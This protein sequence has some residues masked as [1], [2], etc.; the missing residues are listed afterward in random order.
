MLRLRGNFYRK[1]A[2]L[3][4]G[5]SKVSYAIFFGTLFEKNPSL[6]KISVRVIVFSFEAL[7]VD[8]SDAQRKGLVTA[9]TL[10]AKKAACQLNDEEIKNKTLLSLKGCDFHFQQSL[11]KVA[12]SGALSNNKKFITHTNPCFQ[13]M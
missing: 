10:L 2:E 13:L 8:F 11:R 1:F 12:Q 7:A 6:V 4:I 9:L 3:F 5:R